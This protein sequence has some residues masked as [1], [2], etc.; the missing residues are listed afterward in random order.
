M[1]EHTKISWCDSTQ[2]FWVG[3]EKIGPACDDCY[4]EKW[5]IR[6]GRPEL[7]QGTRA[8]TKTWKDSL[9]WEV[10]HETFYA[11]HKRRQRV[12]TCSLADFLDNAVP[13]EWRIDAWVQIRVCQHLEW[14]IV[15]K[16]LPNLLKML[17][18]DWGPANYRHIVIIA[19]SVTQA[20][21]DR[22][23]ER[24]KSLKRLFPWLRVGLSMEPLIEQI[25]MG[26]PW[27]VDWVIVGGESGVINARKCLPE[28]AAQIGAW[29]QANGTPFHFKQVGHNS[30]GWPGRIT[31]KGDTPAEWPKELRVQQFP[32][33]I[34]A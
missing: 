5:A 1:A 14:F 19:T 18:P 29:C 28:W 26:E 10:N 4:A 23:K 13:P 30:T 17:P 32:R 16:R 27:P 8:R 21:Y 15:S 20:E 25:D 33:A 7:W 6:A 34:A 9:S 24:L 22:D 11:V 31:G 2:N 12:F 3:C